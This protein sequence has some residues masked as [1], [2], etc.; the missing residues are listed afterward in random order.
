M[1]CL[2]LTESAM[3]ANTKLAE[4]SRSMIDIV[5]LRMDFLPPEELADLER[6][7]RSLDFPAIAT[8]RKK[9][10]GGLFDGDE[11]YRRKILMDA[12][13]AGFEYVDLEYG[14]NLDY[15]EDA[16]LGK[17]VSVIRS[18]HD[19]T[20]VPDNLKEIIEES[21]GKEGV[22][23]KAA[24]SINSV[25]DAVRLVKVINSVGGTGDRIILGMGE[26]GFFSRIL[27]KK[28][29][30]LLTFCSAGAEK[31]APGHVT[32]EVLV[33]TYN[34]KM[35][36]SSSEVFGIIGNPVMHS[37]SPELHNRGYR[38]LGM[39]AV[40]VPFTVDSLP[41]FFELASLIGIS[42]F[43]VTV[44][45]KR[46]IIPFLDSTDLT[47]EEAGACNTVVKGEEGYTGWNT[48]ISGFLKP[49]EK[50]ISA[51]DI[52]RTAVIGAGGAASAVVRALVR[53]GTE[54]RIFNR[55]AERAAAL[56]ERYG[57]LW[58]PLDSYDRIAEC[59][60]IV[61]TTSVGMHPDTGSTPLPGYRFRPEQIA[62]DIIYAPEVTRFLS[63]ASAAGCRTINGLEML[64]VQGKQQ[65]FLFTGK[66]Y[67]ETGA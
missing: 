56:A 26:Y 21:S 11:K 62:Y 48:D 45:F 24:V 7:R 13:D 60:L 33:D 50:R 66:D 12:V 1:I 3:A 54:I 40:Y 58:Y 30:S 34:L 43:S 57:A 6:V 49:L 31:G 47:V 59:D 28:L 29:G 23:P 61:Q 15:M 18:F 32:P 27:Y 65:F 63:E 25:R 14:E 55:S 46:D 52:K 16:A 22:I 8:F 9:E 38:E 39:D 64:H 44:P 36:S 51:S 17:G 5:E 35:I 41:D 20:G 42:G 10:D 4:A 67:P 37:R 2:T 53:L 19:F